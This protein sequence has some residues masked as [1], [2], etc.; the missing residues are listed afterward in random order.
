[1]Q[2]VL[3]EFRQH[4]LLPEG[5]LNDHQPLMTCRATVSAIFYGDNSSE[6]TLQIRADVVFC[7]SRDNGISKDLPH[8]LLGTMR[9]AVNGRYR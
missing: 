8:A 6:D 3:I 2:H 1:M 9:H 5:L 4:G 7:A